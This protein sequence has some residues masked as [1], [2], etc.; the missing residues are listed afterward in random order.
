VVNKLDTIDNQFRFFKMELLAGDPDYVVEHVCSEIDVVHRLN[1]CSTRRTVVSRSI[2]PKSTGT[3]GFTPN[4]SDW[5]KYLTQRM[6][7]QTFLLVSVRSL[8][9]QPKKGAQY[10]PMIS[11]HKVQNISL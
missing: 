6:S 9:L 8:C 11:T 4:T 2:L 3:R 7:S 5:L 10:W 1:F